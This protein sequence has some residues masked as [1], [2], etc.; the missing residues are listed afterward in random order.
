MCG[1]IAFSLGLNPDHKL[2]FSFRNLTYQFGRITTYSILG[3]V[4]GIVGYG[5]SFSGFQN[6]FSI[7]IGMLMI[8][9]AVLP[10]NLGE[11]ASGLKPFS[12][13]MYQIKS[14]LGKF[15]RRKNYSSLYTTGLLNGLLPCG[16]VY[17]ALTA[18][19]ALGSIAGGAFFMFIFGLGT[20]PLM[21]AA[22]LFGNAISINTRQ[23][24]LKFLPILMVVLGALFII[25][26]LNF[27]IPYISPALESL[28]INGEGHKH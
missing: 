4:L 5:I 25:R 21:F 20:L 1:P 18:S 17:A 12:R 14:G 22:V 23:K 10:K 9:M 19:L 3:A 16:A 28:R 15:I 8:L 7:M 26:G 6:L 24:I 13:L 2:D 27:D 11:N